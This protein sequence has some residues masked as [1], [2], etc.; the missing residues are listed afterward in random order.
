[1]N[2]IINIFPG[3][4]VVIGLLLNTVV[5]GQPTMVPLKPKPYITG[6]KLTFA[7]KYGPIHGGDAEIELRQARINNKTVYH[8]K[9]TAKTIGIAEKLY[10]IKD[11]FE[12]YFDI[13][14]SLPYK[15]IR[16]VKEGN[17][18]SYC[19][20]T[21]Y[22][23]DTTVYSSKADSLYKTIPGILDILSSLY[24]LRSFNPNYFKVGDVIPIFT[25]WD[26]EI[27]PFNLRYKG[28]EIIKTKFGK[29][30][31]FRFDPVV[32]P[33][34]VFKSEDDL[35]VWFTADKNFIPIKAKFELIVGTLR[36]DLDQYTNLRYSLTII[37]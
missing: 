11:I 15:A 13:N 17:Y 21:F 36:C 20:L 9:V 4:I 35:I 8:A 25:F 12:S 19:E 14:T 31:C 29:I 27:F 32:E 30:K 24:Y 33:G 7:L 28:E 18:R 26:D 5:Y 10:S 3:L 1:V 6:E 16:N 22:H 37:E 23:N 34:R 2:K